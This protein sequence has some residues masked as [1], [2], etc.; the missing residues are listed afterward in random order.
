MKNKTQATQDKSTRLQAD[1][2]YS[3]KKCQVIEQLRKRY[4]A[5]SIHKEM[6]GRH[7]D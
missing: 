6:T 5:F 1:Q 7:V 4:N 3:Y 2:Q